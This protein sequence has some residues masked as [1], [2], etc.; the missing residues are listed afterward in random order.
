MRPPAGTLDYRA[1]VLVYA[2]ALLVAVA[3]VIV[4]DGTFTRLAEV[5]FERAWLLAAGLGLQIL[6]DVINLPPS[7]YDDV[8]FGILLLSYVAVL[9]FI[10]SNIRTRG[11]LVIGI[12]I[13]LNVFVI[14]LNAGMPYHVVD[15]LPRETTVKHRPERS[16]DLLPVLSDRFATGSPFRAAISIG[17]L[18]LFAGIVELAYA[19]SR[20]ARRSSRARDQNAPTRYVDLPVAEESDGVID[21]REPQADATTRSSATSTLGS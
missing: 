18:V 1:G 14:A 12:G 10:A 3:V 20:R 4:T 7:R 6:V 5:S 17:D 2:V 21:L 11:I 9:G 16:T 8:G 13:A 19:G 15:G